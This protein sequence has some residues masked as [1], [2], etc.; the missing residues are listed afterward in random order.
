MFLR[1]VSIKN[2][3]WSEQVSFIWK[4]R[5]FVILVQW[6]G[7][8]NK[9]FL[10]DR[11][12][13]FSSDMPYRLLESSGKTFQ[14][15]VAN[16]SRLPCQV[17]LVGGGDLCWEPFWVHI[18]LNSLGK[19]AEIVFHG[20][21]SRTQWLENHIFIIDSEG[22]ILDYEIREWWPQILTAPA[23]PESLSLAGYWK[24]GLQ[25]WQVGPFRI[26]CARPQT[27]SFNAVNWIMFL[28]E[29]GE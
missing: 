11:F 21:G 2:D 22:A 12:I 14:R 9:I 26:A 29:T 15:L 6:W 8:I 17:Q 5:L 28:P 24:L 19:A 20:H 7:W 4:T 13:E 18:W 3:T 27:V 1:K 10:H 23:E 25:L 16:W